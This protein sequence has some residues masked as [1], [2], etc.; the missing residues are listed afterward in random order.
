[1][2]FEPCDSDNSDNA[3]SSR[4]FAPDSDIDLNVNAFSNNLLS[5]ANL[6]ICVTAPPLED[7]LRISGDFV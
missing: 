2:Y 4:K 7:F 6:I 3:V 1:M 5:N